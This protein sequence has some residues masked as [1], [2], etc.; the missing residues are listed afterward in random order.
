MGQKTFLFDFDGTLAE[1]LPAVLKIMDVVFKE[2]K[3]ELEKSVVVDLLKNQ[4]VR[5]VFKKF[6]IPFYRI[7]GLI[8]KYREEYRKEISFLK[9]VADIKETIGKLKDRGIKLGIITTNGK[10]NV[11]EFLKTNQLDIFDYI[12]ADVGVFS[13]GKAI[14]KIIKLNKS[15]PSSTFFVGDETRDIEASRKAGN[16]PEGQN[17]A[18]EGQGEHA[19]GVEDV[20]SR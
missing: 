1:S 13:K 8:K 10:D 17:Q 5:E 7:P 2:Y 3:I 12:S 6:R 18:W 15:D 19:Q 11:T 20:L 14:K 4:G 9:P 16:V